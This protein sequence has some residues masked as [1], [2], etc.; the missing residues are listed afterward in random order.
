M[1]KAADLQVVFKELA[2]VL[3]AAKTPATDYEGLIG[4]SEVFIKNYT[5]FN[6]IRDSV[7]LACSLE[8][9]LTKLFQSGEIQS[10][11]VRVHD[12]LYAGLIPALN[13]LRDSDLL[14]I[15]FLEFPWVRKANLKQET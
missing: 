7:N 10:S 12:H 13:I 4:K 3:G 8:S 9:S 1:T 2:R 15:L 5:Y 6:R 11:P 14:G